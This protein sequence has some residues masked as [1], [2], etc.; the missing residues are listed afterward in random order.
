MEVT[1]LFG[2]PQEHGLV[3][4]STFLQELAKKV[5]RAIS[6][7]QTDGTVAEDDS[8]MEAVPKVFY[9]VGHG[10][11]DRFTIECRTTYIDSS[12][13]ERIDDF[14]DKIVHLLSC[15][16]GIR[17]GH[18]LVD[19]GATAFVGYDDVFYYG[20]VEETQPDP[21][22]HSP[23]ANYWDYYSFID[24]DV[25]VERQFLIKGKSLRQAVAASQK[26]FDEYISMYST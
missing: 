6:V 22:P 25:E 13:Y 23:P 24:C 3:Y 7:I 12:T 18:S 11:Y 4:C 8:A 20:V 5:P 21:E 16:T 9:H 2:E 17:L 15:E 1:A 10:N 14:K 19:H 26:K